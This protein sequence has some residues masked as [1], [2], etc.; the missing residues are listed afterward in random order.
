[1][2]TKAFSEKN[3][4]ELS[5]AISAYLTASS[6]TAHNITMIQCGSSYQALLLYTP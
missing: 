5:D 4:K 6:A 2:L 3:L 1:M